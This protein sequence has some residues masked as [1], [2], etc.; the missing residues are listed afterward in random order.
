MSLPKPF[1]LCPKH[2]IYESGIFKAP[3]NEWLQCGI[4]SENLKA[5]VSFLPVLGESLP[6]ALAI[7]DA[8]FQ[9]DIKKFEQV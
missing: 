5:D 2:A 4:K 8:F 3:D 6:E 7:K 9:C 1:L